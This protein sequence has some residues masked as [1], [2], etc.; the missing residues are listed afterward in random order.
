MTVEEL[1]DTID[2]LELRIKKYEEAIRFILVVTKD[3][4]NR[5]NNNLPISIMSLIIEAGIEKIY[6]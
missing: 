4:Q 1:E 3:Y 2:S 6:K 5:H